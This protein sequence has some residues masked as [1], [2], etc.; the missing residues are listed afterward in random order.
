MTP[1][2]RSVAAL[3]VLLLAG[4][5]ALA[6][7]NGSSGGSDLSPTQALAAAK[8][9]LDRTR[10]VHI[11]LSTGKLPSG[12]NGLLHADGVGTHAPAFK[13]NIKVATSGF[14]ADAAV[15][16]V[17]GQ[18]YAKLPFTT[19]FSKIDPARFGAPD[20]ATMMDPKS[21]LSSLLTEATGVK[22]GQQ[23][24]DGRQVLSTY[25]ATVPGRAVAAILPSASA[26]RSFKATFTVT[27]SNRLDKAVLTGPF[28]PKAGDVTY[29]IAFDRYGVAKTITAP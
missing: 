4:L 18:V 27:D 15:V 24:R 8:H 12:V 23:Q 26:S 21:G 2:P 14:T 7:C 28:Y 25:T 20:P 5:A 29:T 10:G 19:K 13:G 6:G 17:A 22:Q 16:A 3:V 11:V 1:R 9:N